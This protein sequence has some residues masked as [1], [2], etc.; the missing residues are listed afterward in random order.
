MLEKRVY[1]PIL[2]IIVLFFCL[3]WLGY[4]M[5]HN[6]I[7]TDVGDG[8]MHFYISQ[9][10]W[11]DHML[12]LHHWGKPVFVLLSSPFAQFG[13]NGMVIFNSL[14]FLGIILFGY[15]IL[16]KFNVSIWIQLLFPLILLIPTDSS[17]TILGALTEPL[18]NLAAIASLSMLLDKKYFWFAL[19]VSFMPFMRS[20][21][22]LPLLLALLLLIYNRSFKT[23]P[24]LFFGFGIY[25][26]IGFFVY[27][28]FWW[29]YTESPYDMGNGMYGKGTWTHYLTSYKSYLGNPGLYIIMLGIPAAIFLLFK[30]RWKDLQLEWAFYAYGIFIG[31]IVSHSYFWATGQNGSIGLTRIAT[32]GMPIFVLLH[33]YYISRIK[34]F[35]NSIAKGIFVV[36][37]GILIYTLVNTK[38]YPQKATGLDKQVLNVADYLNKMDY[39]HS[40]HTVYYH[41]PLLGF[42]LDVN[43]YIGSKNLI[44]HS[45]YDLE[46]DLKNILKPGDIIIRD[47]HF[48]PIEGNLPLGKLEQHPELVLIKEFISSEQVE[49]AHNET[50][51]LMMFQYI[52][53][54]QQVKSKEQIIKKSIEKR[55][56]ISKNQ[57]YT[58]ITDFI[59][60]IT[61]HSKLTVSITALKDG[62]ILVYDHNNAEEYG[63]SEL[64][65][66]HR[67]VKTYLFPES[68]ETKLYIWN[69]RKLDGELILHAYEI[70]KVNYHPLM[71][72]QR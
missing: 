51:G 56:R 12:F 7:P 63:S 17:G 47:S 66:M 28:N 54:E 35:N 41:F 45:F 62:F 5:L 71:D 50:E 8:V 25:A 61:D 31:V 18:F 9:A 67:V 30:K 72:N 21:G 27:D 42:M 26:I 23:I 40:G 14:V 29:F 43:P 69:P 11:Q 15:R 49:D 58:G 37:S 32:Q 16:S 22:Q 65:K 38:Q 13:F 55:I 70:E 44:Y 10:S 39:K 24:V 64:Q 36:F 4:F 60:K 1:E 68:G 48:G 46:N 3:S 34:L 57:E 20:E 19:I 59:P 2:K 52:P 53:I 6:E 33:L